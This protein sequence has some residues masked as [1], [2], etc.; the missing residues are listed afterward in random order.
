MSLFKIGHYTDLKGGT[1]CTVILCPDGTKGSAHARGISPGTREYALLSPFRKIEEIHALLLTGGSAFGLDAAAGVMRYLVERSK[2]YK[3]SY[4]IIPIVP[5][6]VIFD[7]PV[8]DASAYPLPENA[9]IACKNAKVDHKEQGTIGAGTGATVGKWAGIAHM[10]KSGIGIEQ[11]KFGDV[12]VESLAVVNSVGDIVDEKGKIIAGAVQN[13]KFI[14]DTAFPSQP[15]Q[16]PEMDFGENTVLIAIMTNANLSKVNLYYLA[17]RAHN[18]IVRA[19][20]PA[21]TSF[22]GDVVF[23]MS[24]GGKTIDIETITQMSIEATRRSIINAVIH[25]SSLDNIPTINMLSGNIS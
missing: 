3:T 11:V 14:A 22:D 21:H 2:G 10:M 7:L 24:T 18:G 8:K 13:G 12:W 25:A 6:A 23:S 20:K 5:A 9:Y 17:E 15:W 19:V 1:G 4:G 16:V